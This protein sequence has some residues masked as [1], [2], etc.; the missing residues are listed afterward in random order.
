M[1]YC[2]YSCSR[3]FIYYEWYEREEGESSKDFARRE[4]AKVPNAIHYFYLQDIE[5]TSILQ[6]F[7]C[8]QKIIHLK[9][10]RYNELSGNFESFQV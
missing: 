6:V 8:P 7:S 3:S 5:D 9:F 4:K 10:K 1:I 2:V